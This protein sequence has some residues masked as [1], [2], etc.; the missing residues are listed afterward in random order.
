MTNKTVVLKKKVSRK[1]GSYNIRKE[2][3]KDSSYYV[4][5]SED[6]QV[7]DRTR[8]LVPAPTNLFFR[9]TKSETAA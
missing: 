5:R 8:V 7:L 1:T 9:K 2:V 3:G 6:G 4:T